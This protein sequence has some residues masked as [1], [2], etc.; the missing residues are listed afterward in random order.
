MNIVNHIVRE[1]YV[2]HKLLYRNQI[3]E[4]IDIDPK[5]V[6]S[7]FVIKTVN[8]KIDQVL[9]KNPHPNANPKTGDFCI[10]S[11]LR[12]HELSKNTIKMIENM[13]CCFNLDDCYFT[14][15]DE[16]KYQKQEVIGAW[17]RNIK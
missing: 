9:L 17:K 2:P 12:E 13:L 4:I 7:G 16:I 14:P 3:H 6:I 15:W 8:D 1:V 10:P 5:F 11:S